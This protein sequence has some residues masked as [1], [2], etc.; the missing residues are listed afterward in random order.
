MGRAKTTTTGHHGSGDP[1]IIASWVLAGVVLTGLMIGGWRSARNSGSDLSRRTRQIKRRG[2]ILAA[3]AICAESVLLLG[4][5]YGSAPPPAQMQ[6][7]SVAWLQDHLGTY[8]FATLGPIQPNYGSYFG[9]TQAN[10]TDL[11]ISSDWVIY[12]NSMLD[13]NSPT[14]IFTGA[15]TV[16]PQAESPADEFTSHL[17]NFEA[18]GVR[19]IVT[20]ANGLDVLGSRFPTPGT[21]PWPRGPRVVY[22]DRFAEIWQL[23]SPAP[24]FSLLPAS[25]R[26]SVDTSFVGAGCSVTGDGPD[27]ATVTCT[28]PSVLLRQVADIPGWSASVNG[29]PV[30]VQKDPFGSHGLFQELPV[31][32][33]TST[34][35]F[36]F[37]PPYEFPAF[38]AAFLALVAI[39]G[40][41]L[42]TPERLRRLRRLRWRPAGPRGEPSRAWR[43]RPV[44]GPPRHRVSAPPRRRPTGPPRHRVRGRPP[45][46]GGASPDAPRGPHP[47]TD[48]A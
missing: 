7:G 27:Q 16:D 25:P 9:I 41:F 12:V 19:Y 23:P 39:L 43:R 15:A 14:L 42:L 29:K 38:A 31:P 46:G 24:L 22:R 44:A 35:Q 8:R 30:S 45:R 34:V 28:R 18:I 36:T 10:T 5:T 3:A 47:P 4:F 20:N 6:L 48:A 2:R 37:L 11:P 40:S 21:A 13:T 33:G 1:Y 26:N 32:A 17:A